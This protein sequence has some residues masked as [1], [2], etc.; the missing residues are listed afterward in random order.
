MHGQERIETTQEQNLCIFHP[1][2]FCCTIMHKEK[3]SDAKTLMTEFQAAAAKSKPQSRRGKRTCGRYTLHDQL[4]NA[5]AYLLL[6]QL[7]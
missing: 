4:H 6:H 7:Y 2:S 5:A 3:D 1:G